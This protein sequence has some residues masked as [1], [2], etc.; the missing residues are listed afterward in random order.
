MRAVI[1]HTAADT[2]LAERAARVLSKFEPLAIPL[3]ANASTF[4]CGPQLAAVLVWSERAAAEGLGETVARAASKGCRVIVWL[5]DAAEA[6]RTL[7]NAIVAPA[8]WD[9]HALVRPV[10]DMLRRNQRQPA[11]AG[12]DRPA[13]ASVASGI[14]LGALLGF[15]GVGLAA[16]DRIEA[17]NATRSAILLAQPVD[18]ERAERL[19]RTH[20]AALEPTAPYVTVADAREVAC[21]RVKQAAPFYVARP[22]C[23]QPS[24]ADLG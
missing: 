12:V 10:S 23:V 2:A 3:A 6:P 13:M 24:V 11:S 7:P 5:T 22:T 8:A 20:F 4:V 19:F 21:A 15:G 18:R 9:E 14:A 17:L 16:K 1:F